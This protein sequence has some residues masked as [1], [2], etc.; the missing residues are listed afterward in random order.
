MALAVLAYHSHHV[1]GPGMGQRVGDGT[2]TVLLHGQPFLAVQARADRLNDGH[3]IFGPRVVAGKH[4]LVGM[5][6]GQTPH[7]GPFGDVTVAPAAEDTPEL[8]AA[9]ASQGP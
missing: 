9:L 7:Q 3:R 6:L 4:D 2:A 1:V 5:L 8:T